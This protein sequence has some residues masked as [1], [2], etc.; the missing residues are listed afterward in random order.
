MMQGQERGDLPPRHRRSPYTPTWHLQGPPAAGNAHAAYV[1]HIPSASTM[2]SRMGQMAPPP[3]QLAP[4]PPQPSRAQ[5]LLV[6]TPLEQS[7]RGAASEAEAHSMATTTEKGLQTRM[8]PPHP[9]P[10]QYMP[11]PPQLPRNHDQLLMP[12]PQ[13]PPTPYRAQSLNGSGNG[14]VRSAPGLTS[15]TEKMANMQTTYKQNAG[16]IDVDMTNNSDSNFQDTDF[17]TEDSNIKSLI[18]IDDQYQSSQAVKD[19]IP[20]QG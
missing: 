8:P 15:I 13:R 7:M 5:Q 11:P 18:T 9:P 12:P 19:V 16:P 20:D 4:P 6:L 14:Q 10:Y 2:G 17:R 1:K 3:Y